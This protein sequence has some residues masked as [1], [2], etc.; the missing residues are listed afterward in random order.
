MEQ[1]IQ[2][3]CPWCNAV[4]S[5]HD[6]A[7]IEN[8]FVTCPI[9]KHKSPFLQYERVVRTQNDDCT[10]YPSALQQIHQVNETIGRIISPNGATYQLKMGKNIIGRKA[11]NS[12]ADFQ[13]DTD[14]NRKMSREHLIIDVK[15]IPSKGIV[16]YAS[17]YKEKVNKTFIGSETLVYGDCIVLKDGDI[18]KLSDIAVKFEIPDESVTQ[19]E[20]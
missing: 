1:I 18:I 12:T 11:S 19:L 13:I 3:K 20:S 8:K 9:C 15:N 7:G 4:L 10:K 16:H 5:V 14:E 6:Q 2:I 17:L